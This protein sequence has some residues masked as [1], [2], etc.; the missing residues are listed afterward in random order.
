MSFWHYPPHNSTRLVPWCP[1]IRAQTDTSPL[2]GDS[3]RSTIRCLC[4]RFTSPGW[5]SQSTVPT[6]ASL[7]L[8][9]KRHPKFPIQVLKHNV[10]WHHFDAFRFLK[11]FICNFL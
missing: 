8:K 11:D 3:F 1:L 6:C 10:V 2:M 9:L 4:S 7:D 5:H